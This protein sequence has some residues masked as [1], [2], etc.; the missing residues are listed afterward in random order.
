[1]EK[2]GYP[3]VPPWIPRQVSF[4]PER[5]PLFSGKA[6]TG[7]GTLSVDQERRGIPLMVCPL[8]APPWMRAS[9]CVVGSAHHRNNNVH[10]TH[11]VPGT[12]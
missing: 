6:L 1:M 7:N 12:I 10:C 9:L 3:E 5:A 8:S 11:F 2:L 4:L